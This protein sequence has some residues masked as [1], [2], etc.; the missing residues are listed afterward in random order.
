MGRR[1]RGSLVNALASVGIQI[2]SCRVANG[3][4]LA[5]AILADA[6]ALGGTA[7]RGLKLAAWVAG[8]ESVDIFSGSASALLTWVKSLVVAAL[9][10]VALV[11]GEAGAG[12]WVLVVAWRA[13]NDL[14]ALSVAVWKAVVIT[15]NIN[16]LASAAFGKNLTVWA[17]EV[18]L[19]LAS[20]GVKLKVSFALILLEVAGLGVASVESVD[21][22][23]GGA[24]AGLT[25]VKSLAIWA[26]LLAL[27]AGEA[28]AGVWV[29][30][31]TLWALNLLGALLHVSLGVASECSSNIDSIAS[32]GLGV[33]NLT[34]SALKVAL[35]L[36]L[37]SVKLKVS[38]AITFSQLALLSRVASVETH[39]GGVVDARADLTWVKLLTVLALVLALVLGEAVARV[40]VLVVAFWAHDILSALLMASLGAI[41]ITLD[42]DGHAHAVLGVKDLTVSALEVALAL[43][44]LVIE[45][46]VSG[47]LC[48]VSFAW[49]AHVERVDFLDGGALANLT[50]VKHATFSA[51][52]SALVLGE[53]VAG[54]GVLVE[55]LW[56]F[57]LLS[58]H[59]HSFLVASEITLDIDGIA[60][61]H[62][63]V[64]NLTIF[65]LSIALTLASLLIEGSQVHAVVISLLA[66]EL[67]GVESVDLSGLGACALS[68]WVKDLTIGAA[69]ASLRALVRGEALASV[70]VEVVAFRA[71]LVSHGIALLA[72][73]VVASESSGLGESTIATGGWGVTMT[74]H[75]VAAHHVATHLAHHVATHLAH[76]AE[77]ATEVVI[78]VES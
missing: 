22:L 33:K 76:A 14:S 48:W 54:V 6:P 34:V 59:L 25:W 58:A 5:L 62:I 31:V 17:L 3:I 66:A 38:F 29:L 35:A 72:A 23:V 43:A 63:S 52:L 46:K 20:I 40:W 24:L 13:L 73:E 12:V 41:E 27:V 78:V 68:T 21:I 56:A 36:A 42:I 74:T 55:A 51:V 60:G 16:G 18:A 9:S 77:V 2:L 65:A 7:I 26:V 8:K 47:A 64:K 53:A 15:L 57:D 61:T 11:L 75:H 44:G 69:S 49:R 67:A 70:L 10:V 45:L 30:V 1:G 19:A 37:D 4:A 28:V 71:A 50:W 32:A 39:D